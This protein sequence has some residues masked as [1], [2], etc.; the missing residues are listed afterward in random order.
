LA[1][2]IKDDGSFVYGYDPV[3]GEEL[4]SYNILRHAG[5]VWCLINYYE[6]TGDSGVIEAI[7]S[8]LGYLEDCIEYLGPD[9]AYVVERKD[10][11]IKLGGNAIALLAYIAYMETFDTDVYQNLCAA[12]A[13]GILELLDHETGKYYHVLNFPD[14]SEKEEYRTVYYDG[15]ATYALAKMYSF[16]KDGRYLD[17]AASAADNFIAGDY[18]QYHDHWVSYSV[19]ELTKYLPEE[20]YL[21]FGLKNAQ[22]NLKTIKNADTTS[23][24]YME[25][26]MAAFELYDRVVA[27]YGDLKYLEEFD[28][29]L[30]IETIFHRADYMLNGYFYPEY[31]MYMENP[32]LVAGS[33][34]VR[35]ETYRVRIDDIQHFMG[36]YMLY[37]K[38]YDRLEQYRAAFENLS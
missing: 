25:L 34:F 8:G 3:S 13:E 32:A 2:L 37:L 33:F 18:E 16:T 23:H 38:H 26:A 24:I 31:A 29:E 1:N 7:L 30:L 6:K 4:G 14:F 5:T 10:N 17:A 21:A 35:H 9:T 19:N 27:D 36:G 22:D 15:E 28:A 20:K 12:L 11:E